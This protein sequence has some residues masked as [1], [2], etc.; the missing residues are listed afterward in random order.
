[1]KSIVRWVYLLLVGLIV[2]TGALFIAQGALDDNQK[3]PAVYNP[4]TESAE[5]PQS[6][7]TASP[8]P[9]QRTPEFHAPD[10]SAQF[11]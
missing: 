8:A 11:I 10:G 4:V 5:T 9:E 1:M 7:D 2:L 3:Q 6:D